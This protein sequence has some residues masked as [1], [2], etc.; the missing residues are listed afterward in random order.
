MGG[1]KIPSHLLNLAEVPVNTEIWTLPS[2]VQTAN[3]ALQQVNNTQAKG[4]VPVIMVADQIIKHIE[5]GADM[6]EAE[7]MLGHLTNGLGLIMASNNQ[8]HRERRCRIQ[9]ELKK[10]YR[11]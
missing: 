9:Q 3:A 2:H 7:S 5:C 4:L 6:P 8:L 10:C 1:I 11:G